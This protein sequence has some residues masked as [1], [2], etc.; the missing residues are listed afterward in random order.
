MIH[1]WRFLE[2]KFKYDKMGMYPIDS[3]ENPHNY[4][5]SMLCRLYGIPNNTKFFIEWVPLIDACINCHIMNW[6]TILSDNLSTTIS[7]Y[8]QKRS[9]STKNLP[10][11]YMS[12]YIME[13]ICFYTKF[14]IMGWKQTLQDPYPIHLSHKKLWESHYI[15]HFY[16]ICNGVMLHLLQMI[17]D[18]KAPI[19]SKEAA[20]YHLVVGKH[21]IE[22]WFIYI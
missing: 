9:T 10:P 8:H 13:S 1:G 19:F 18:K 20:T 4:A 12:S 2:N 3:L 14:P 22:Q 21:F 17:F 15:P 11:F 16:K 5:G 7:E 6:S